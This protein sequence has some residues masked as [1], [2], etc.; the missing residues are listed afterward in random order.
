MHS[1]KRITQQMTIANSLTPK[2][3]KQKQ[4][5]PLSKSKEEVAEF[6]IFNLDDIDTSFLT[7]D[8][9]LEEIVE[10]SNSRYDTTPQERKEFLDALTNDQKECN[11]EKWDAFFTDNR[12]KKKIPNTPIPTPKKNRSPSPSS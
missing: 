3:S 11:R 2:D 9:T 5:D 4:T 6:S 8:F 7:R 1:S 10:L 12:Q